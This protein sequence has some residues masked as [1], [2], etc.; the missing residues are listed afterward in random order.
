MAQTTTA[1]RKAKGRTQAA[2]KVKGKSIFRVRSNVPRT[3]TRLYLRLSSLGSCDTEQI[4][5][6][7]E[8]FEVQFY[9]S[10]TAPLFA[11]VFIE[12]QLPDSVSYTATDVSQT[13]TTST[14]VAVTAA[15]KCWT[16]LGSGVMAADFNKGDT[17]KLVI[18][19]QRVH[20]ATLECV[21]RLSKKQSNSSSAK[22][23]AIVD[24]DWKEIKRLSDAYAD[25]VKQ[26]TRM[27]SNVRELPP[28]AFSVTNQ[29][30]ALLPVWA[31]LVI[32][33][34]NTDRVRDHSEEHRLLQHWW[35][36]ACRNV[37]AVTKG[38]G[39]LAADAE[40]LSEMCTL[41][42]RAWTYLLDSACSGAN[43]C[44]GVDEWTDVQ[45]RTA[46][47]QA[48][49]DCE[50]GAL[51]VLRNSRL[52]ATAP[53][54]GD[55]LYKSERALEQ[56]YMS[57]LLIGTLRLPTGRCTYH[58][59]SAKIDRRIVRD[60]FG[61]KKLRGP[62]SDHKQYLPTLVIETTQS[63]ASCRSYAMDQ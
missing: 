20:V 6:F 51:I 8:E 9:D 37:P 15:A 48:T 26:L 30:F 38:E 58:A 62:F 34:V 40:R 28:G 21:K 11:A 43:V 54:R 4:Q 23:Q 25:R 44:S 63:T 61:V 36:I 1:E 39:R 56:R 31:F 3:S 33:L 24:I 16:V 47:N 29:G 5:R 52:I 2:E 57:F 12:Q 42:L 60:H 10:V 22:T 49:Y 32:N 13:T 41:P 7:D 46:E 27:P 19:H 50:D 55:A 45:V 17:C 59:I 53:E 14:A 35:R 18:G